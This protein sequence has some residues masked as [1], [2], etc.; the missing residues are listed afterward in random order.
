MPLLTKR[1]RERG[2]YF[3]IKEVTRATGKHVLAAP[4]QARLQAGVV[5]LPDTPFFRT[6]FLQEHLAFKPDSKKHDDMI[7][8]ISNA[9]HFLPSTFVPIVPRNKPVDPVGDEEEQ[10]NRILKNAKS[11]KYDPTQR[12]KFNGSK[13]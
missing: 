7:D 10:W 8:A 2:V 1:M 9:V 5:V 13:Y 12:R 11:H 3:T 4:Y 6:T